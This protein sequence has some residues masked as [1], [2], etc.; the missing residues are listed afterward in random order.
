MKG[1]AESIKLLNEMLRYE[2][3]AINIYFVQGKMAKNWGYEKLNAIFQKESIEEMKHAEA[4]ID[5]ILYLEGVPNMAAYN[6]MKIGADVQKMLQYNWEIEK[7]AIDCLNHGIK[8]MVDIGDNGTREL[9]AK[10]LIDEEEHAD[11]IEAQ[12]HAIGE[13]G[14]ARYLTEHLHSS[15]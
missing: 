12:L 5:R 4:I 13:I 8:K 3:T 1:H 2:L 11:W 6:K 14:L 15:T 10:I 7:A 9:A